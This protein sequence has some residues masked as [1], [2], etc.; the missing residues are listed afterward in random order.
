MDFERQVATDLSLGVTYTHR[1]YRDTTAIV[2][3]GVTS[4]DFAPD[5]RIYR[6]TVLGNFTVPLFIFTGEHDGDTILTNANEYKTS[7]NGVDIAL[8]KRMSNNFMLNGGFTYQK[9]K[10]N[11]RWRRF[12]RFLHRRWW[13]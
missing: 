4:A 13:S 5:W 1:D 6:E 3:F 8:R 10:A 9:Q 2:P 12:T 7:Y 11:L